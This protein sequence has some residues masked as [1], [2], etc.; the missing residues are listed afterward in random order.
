MEMTSV[1]LCTTSALSKHIV[2]IACRGHS[3]STYVD[4]VQDG[5]F[6]KFKKAT[7]I[8]KQNIYEKEGSK[9]LEFV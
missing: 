6:Q 8:I 9:M 2:A 7:S 5:F 3:Q 1:Y 4:N